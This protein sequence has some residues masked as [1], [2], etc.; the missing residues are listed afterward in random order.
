MAAVIVAATNQQREVMDRLRI[1][2]EPL[3]LGRVREQRKERQARLWAERAM[4]R[5]VAR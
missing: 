4:L 5:G 1:A 3:D 2:T